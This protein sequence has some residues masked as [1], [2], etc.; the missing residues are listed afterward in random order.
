MS[1]SAPYPTLAGQPV[2]GGSTAVR[3]ITLAIAGSLAL[4]LSAKIQIP[5]WR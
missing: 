1:A 2:T 4:W 5:F 3:N